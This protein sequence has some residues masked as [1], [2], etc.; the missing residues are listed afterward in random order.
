MTCIQSNELNA[1]PINYAVCEIKWLNP[2]IF[3]KQ[4]VYIEIK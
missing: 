1:R 4:N 2:W 3:L